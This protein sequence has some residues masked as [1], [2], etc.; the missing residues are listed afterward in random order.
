M[1]KMTAGPQFTWVSVGKTYLFCSVSKQ[2]SGMGIFCGNKWVT[3]MWKQSTSWRNEIGNFTPTKRV[4]LKFP[5]L[6]VTSAR[7]DN[8]STYIANSLYAWAC[9]IKM[10]LHFVSDNS[11]LV[12]GWVIDS[13]QTIATLSFNNSSNSLR[14]YEKC[15]EQKKE[16]KKAGSYSATP[17]PQLPI[18]PAPSNYPFPCLVFEERFD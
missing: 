11:F 1:T 16:E 10:Y 14:P 18:P 13:I 17:A 12:P 8:P 15:R 7:P 3:T 5:S 9:P 6:Q 4:E 2:P